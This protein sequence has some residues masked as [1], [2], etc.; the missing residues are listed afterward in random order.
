MATDLTARI[1][2]DPNYQELKSK[3]SRFGWRL[4]VRCCWS[5]TA[6]SA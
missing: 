5:I 1:V 2:R 3:R 6:T 4:S